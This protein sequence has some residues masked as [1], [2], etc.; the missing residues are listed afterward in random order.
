M[1]PDEERKKIK[2]ANDIVEVIGAYVELKASGSN[3]VGLC[4]FHKEKT[5]SFNVSHTKQVFHCFGCQK[6]GDVFSFVMALE[7]VTFPQAMERLAARA[8]IPIDQRPKPAVNGHDKNGELKFETIC[9]YDYVDSLDNLVY[10]V[11]RQHAACK[12][13]EC[14]YVKTFRQRRPVSA[15]GWIWDME[16]V[17]RVLYRLPDVL[18]SKQVWICEGEKDADTLVKM[19]FCATCNVGGAGK[20]MEGYTESLSKKHVV[21]CGDNDEPGQKHVKTVFDSI[22]GKVKTLRVVKVP[23]SFKDVTDYASSF[24]EP[25]VAKRALLDLHQMAIPFVKGISLPIFKVSELEPMYQRHVM[26]MSETAYEISKWLPG[27]ASMRSLVPGELVLLLGATGIGKTA[28][29]SN[30][31]VSA[32]PLPTLFF[33]MELPPELMYERMIALK[34]NMSCRDVENAYRNGDLLGE[35]AIDQKLSHI[36]ICTEARQSVADLEHL[37]I[38][39]ELKI[40]QRPK[41]VLVDYVGLVR[42]VGKSRY[43]RVSQV[44]EDMKVLAK[45]TQTIV[46][47]ASQVA[48]REGDEPEIGLSDGKDSGSLENSSGLVLGMWRKAEDTAVVKVLK[49]TKGGAGIELTCNYNVNTLAITERSRFDDTDVPTKRNQHAND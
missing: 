12:E 30:I 25:E 19:G 21:I 29:L 7:G 37:I 4:P 20:W 1:I 42:G 5:G 9:T 45:A 6:S 14:G 18:R 27:F 38:K 40:G 44:A 10:Q 24:S 23:E 43:E 49:S 33:E 36:H 47:V 17:E 48:R 35:D 11:V 39:S 3:M 34:T 31:A 15:G 8:R 16:G 28:A 32:F 2:A 46:I 26:R 13:K 41:L 22:A